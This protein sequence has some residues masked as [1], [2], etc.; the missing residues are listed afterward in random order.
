MIINYLV[1]FINTC[2]KVS[3]LM[4]HFSLINLSIVG[5]SVCCWHNLATNCDA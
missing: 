1:L 5:Y 4:P 2:Y 3:I